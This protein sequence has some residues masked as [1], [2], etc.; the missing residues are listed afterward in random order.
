MPCFS[1][2]TSRA[3]SSVICRHLNLV[4]AAASTAHLAV[5]VSAHGCSPQ[6][7]HGLASLQLNLSSIQIPLVTGYTDMDPVIVTEGQHQQQ[8]GQFALVLSASSSSGPI[9]APARINFELIE[10][11]QLTNAVK[12][13]MAAVDA[14][15]EE[16][17]RCRT[18]VSKKQN[19]AGSLQ[20]SYTE[21]LKKAQTHLKDVP[22]SLPIT[23]HQCQQ[24]LANVRPSRQ[25]KHQH[26]MQPH[27]YQQVMAIPGVVGFMSEL[28]FVEDESN[29][30]LLSWIARSKLDLLVVTDKE[31]RW[32]VDRRVPGF[33]YQILVLSLASA[34]CAGRLLPHS[35]ILLLMTLMPTITITIDCGF[36][37]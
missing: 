2:C 12:N 25:A 11:S 24:A 37:K 4:T 30:R 9:L 34:S 13:A 33:V 22:S 8:Q 19:H 32:A 7:L 23:L 26:S 16:V 20:K 18:A 36:K 35:G 21:R 1:S 31:A 15:N 5:S 17:R 10:A 27:V 14:A 6:S 28:V 29:A 3:I